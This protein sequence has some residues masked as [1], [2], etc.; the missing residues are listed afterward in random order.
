MA[1]WLS[2]FLCSLL[3]NKTWNNCLYSL[4]SCLHFSLSC[5]LQSI[6]HR[7]FSLK[8]CLSETDHSDFLAVKSHSHFLCLYQTQSL[9]NIWHSWPLSPSWETSFWLV[10]DHTLLSSSLSQFP[11]LVAPLLPLL[12]G[13]PCSAHAGISSSPVDLNAIF[14]PASLRLCLVHLEVSLVSQCN[15]AKTEFLISITCK[16]FP[17][18]IFLTSV[19]DNTNNWVN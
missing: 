4:S 3:Y 7:C 12:A 17:S 8:W 11:L 6:F 14:I 9:F 10:W 2:P 16:T 13:M 15:M 5:S 1:A 19:H 18:S